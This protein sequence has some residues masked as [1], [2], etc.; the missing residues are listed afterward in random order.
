MAAT[1]KAPVK[2][3]AKR[4]APAKKTAAR[5]AP[6]RKVDKNQSTVKKPV[7]GGRNY[8]KKGTPKG[9]ARPG[10]GRPKAS[11]TTKT[12]EVADKL[13]ESGELTPLEYMLQVMRE[14]PDDLK[15][16]YD[17][18]EIDAVQYAVEYK[19]LVARRDNAA[20]KACPYIHPR[21]ASIEA[22]VES[23]GHE[24]WLALLEG[25]GEAK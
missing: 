3:A 4:K 22:K 14:T 24:A 25:M 20:E 19:M 23:S 18:G 1:K 21:L 9:G 12:R 13:V 11:T 5:K 2:K 6:A 17:R 15:A 10:A 7:T 16:K 8:V